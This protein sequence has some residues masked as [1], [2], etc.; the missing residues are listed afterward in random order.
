M[1]KWLRQFVWVIGLWLLLMGGT[2]CALFDRYKPVFNLSLHR[3]VRRDAFAPESSLVQPVYDVM[4]RNEHF[5]S[6]FPIVDSSCFGEAELVRGDNGKWGL[7]MRLDRKGIGLWRQATGEYGSQTMVIL[8]DG[9][10]CGTMMIPPFDESGY[11]MLPPLWSELEARRIASHVPSN[12]R[13]A[14]R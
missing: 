11:L 5:V 13:K 1:M 2:G 10:F 6:R 14:N 4:G 7:R 3:E 9:Y 8:L 12:Y